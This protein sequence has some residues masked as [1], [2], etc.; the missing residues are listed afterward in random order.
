[1][2]AIAIGF[3]DVA[4]TRGV[5]RPIMPGHSTVYTLDRR[6]FR[7]VLE[8]IGSVGRPCAFRKA[9]TAESSRP[10]LLLTFDDGALSAW[11]SVAEELER[12]GW[13]GHFF[14]VTDWIARP[15]FLDRR[16]IR[17]LWERGH[18][19][20]SHS[21][22]H[23]ARM[24]SLSGGELCRQWSESRAILSDVIGDR[25]DIA[26]VPGGYYSRRV[27]RAAADAGIELL[28]TSEPRTKAS[29]VENCLVLGRYTVRAFTPPRVVAAI[30]G[31]S[32]WPYLKQGSLWRL[33]NVA[34]R[35]T[36]PYY[37]PIRRA[38]LAQVRGG[39]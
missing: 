7:E 26:S 28:F 39:A 24:S 13:R 5:V 38:L 4:E 23:P 3:H 33:S 6:R 11:S 1:M 14:V 30:A 36:G 35:L 22:S 15:G 37:A 9:E 8:A 2:R 16:R 27:A 19:I 12:L 21:C 17:D 29:K 20:G 34:K 25:V 10:P 31:G 32:R 18:V